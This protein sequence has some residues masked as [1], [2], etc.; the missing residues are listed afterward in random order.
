MVR[1]KQREERGGGEEDR[2]RGLHTFEQDLSIPT[3]SRV[4]YPN[5]IPSELITR[6]T[7]V[8]KMNWRGTISI[9]GDV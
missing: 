2:M 8:N 5:S 9:D 1:K 3:S 4:M 7:W 6:E